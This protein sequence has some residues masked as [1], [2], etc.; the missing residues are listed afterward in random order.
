MDFAGAFGADFV[1]DDA[2][3]LF[4]DGG[5]QLAPKGVEGP[6]FEAAFENRILDAQAPVFADFGGA[7]KAF[8]IANIVGDEGEHLEFAAT[9]VGAVA[10]GGQEGGEPV[11]GGDVGDRTC[12][13]YTSPSPRD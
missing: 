11:V 2:V 4:L 5:A 13:L 9:V 12:L 1:G 3:A 7:V 6:A 10:G 8:G